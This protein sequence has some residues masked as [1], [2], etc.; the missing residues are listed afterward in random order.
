MLTAIAAELTEAGWS[1]SKRLGKKQRAHLVEGVGS[2]QDLVKLLLVGGLGS[3]DAAMSLG[4]RGGGRRGAGP[5]HGGALRTQPRIGSRVDPA[6]SYIVVFGMYLNEPTV[7][8]HGNQR[9]NAMGEVS[10]KRRTVADG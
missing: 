5:S 4:E 9:T 3:F 1:R 8:V 2:V 6:W 7:V 10:N